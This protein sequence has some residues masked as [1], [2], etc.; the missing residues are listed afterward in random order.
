MKLISTLFFS[1]QYTC[2]NIEKKIK[3]LNIKFIK[4]NVI[5]QFTVSPMFFCINL[6]SNTCTFQEHVYINTLKMVK[7]QTLCRLQFRSQL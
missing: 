5:Y 2:T 7:Q 1:L 6:R 4:L 3:T